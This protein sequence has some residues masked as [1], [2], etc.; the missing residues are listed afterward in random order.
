MRTLT[1]ATLFVVDGPRGAYFAIRENE[2]GTV[3]TERTE[4]AAASLA[5]EKDMI[6]VDRREIGHAELLAMLGSQ[7]EERAGV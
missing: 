6:I 5:N 7:C 1:D 2:T 4:L 3:L